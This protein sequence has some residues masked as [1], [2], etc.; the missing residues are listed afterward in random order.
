MVP[1]SILDWSRIVTELGWHASLPQRII[2]EL[3]RTENGQTLPN[4]IEDFFGKH[5]EGYSKSWSHAHGDDLAA[6]IRAIRPRRTEVALDVATGT[7]F[8]ALALSHSVGHVTGLD[9]TD[10][11]LGQARLLAA[12]Q[13]VTNVRFELGD[14][15]TIDYPDSSFDLVTARRATHHFANVPRF[16]REAKRVLR[17]EGRLGIVDMSPPE[18]SERFSN[19]IERLRDKSHIQAFTPRAWKSMVLGVGFRIDS[20]EVISEPVTFR[21]WLYPVEPGGREEEAVRSAWSLAPTVVKGLLGA[22]FDGSTVK[23]WMKSR[24]VLVASKPLKLNAARN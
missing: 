23:G 24:I 19:K 16:L 15:M 11:M 17:P 1:E 2:R 5:A 14:A 10:E 9:M 6:L 20:A 3:G 4:S 22:E 8:T 21:G 12:K 18:G 13:G 7:G